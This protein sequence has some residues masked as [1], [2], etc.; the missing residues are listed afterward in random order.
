M[1]ARGE[2]AMTDIQDR[3]RDDQ[4]AALGITTGLV[5]VSCGLEDAEDLLADLLAAL[6]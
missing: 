4:K 6:G 2:R 3:I 1:T 5:G